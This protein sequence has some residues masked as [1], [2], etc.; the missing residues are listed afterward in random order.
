[1]HK[2][3]GSHHDQYIHSFADPARQLFV[4]HHGFDSLDVVKKM[5]LYE[6]CLADVVRVLKIIQHYSVHK[7]VPKPFPN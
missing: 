4:D 7:S 3:A 6:P 5:G 2:E 1:M